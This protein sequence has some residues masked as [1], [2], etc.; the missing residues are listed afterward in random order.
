MVL[1]IYIKSISKRISTNSSN[2][3]IFRDAAPYYN[4][5]LKEAGYSEVI[6]YQASASRN[7]RE[8]RNLQ[9]ERTGRRNS[10][11][12]SQGATHTGIVLV[13]MTDSNNLLVFSQ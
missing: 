11:R 13:K 12:E 6:K 5:R 8:Q 7:E 4:A 10:Q 3:D 9:G 2:E 1:Q